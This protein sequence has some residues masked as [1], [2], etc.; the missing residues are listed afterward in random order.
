MMITIRHTHADGTVLSGSTPGDGVWEIVRE[1][2]F[3]YARSV[4][5]YIRGSR[6][7]DANRVLIDAAAQALRA[8]GYEV[9]V[10]VDDTWRPAADREAD[11]Q[12]RAGQRVQRLTGRAQKAA[13]RGEAARARAQN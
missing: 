2:G 6:D 12:A 10:V 9:D 11:R 13:A 5:I 4:G 8:A 3:R 1:H 7:R